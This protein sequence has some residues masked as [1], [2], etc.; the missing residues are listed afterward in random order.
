MVLTESR[1]G[2]PAPVATSGPRGRPRIPGGTESTPYLAAAR[3]TC[4]GRRGLVAATTTDSWGPRSAV[5]AFVIRASAFVID[6]TFGFRHSSFVSSP[7][8]DTAGV[9]SE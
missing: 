4:F 2:R 1:L 6:S 5:Y 7:S 3:A 9:V 8:Q